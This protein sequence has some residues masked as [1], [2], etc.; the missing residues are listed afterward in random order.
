[1]V[2]EFKIKII[3]SEDKSLQ[4]LGELLSNNTSRKI[5]RL[6]ISKESYTNEIAKNLK[7]RVSLVIHHLKKLEELG[8]VEVSYKKIVKKG[9]EHRYFRMN[10]YIFL[11]PNSTVEDIHTK[12][13]TKFYF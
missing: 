3:G 11:A 13:I 1:M 12:G 5:I 8:I 7:L 2:D 4:L 10:P 6:L 9:N